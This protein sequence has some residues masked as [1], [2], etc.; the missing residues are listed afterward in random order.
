MIGVPVTDDPLAVAADLGHLECY[1]D[2]DT[3][4]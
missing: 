4:L 2:L 1:A 3:R